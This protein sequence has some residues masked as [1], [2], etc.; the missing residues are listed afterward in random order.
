M[1][2]NGLLI[3]S[4]QFILV[5][6]RLNAFISVRK[7]NLP[8]LNMTYNNNKIKQFHLIEYFGCYLDANL[9]GE[10]MAMKS[11]KK[12]NAKLQFLNRQN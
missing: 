4:C 5:K 3:I 2:E 6:M 11:L 7:K 1:C 9:N 8:E 12:I 10:S